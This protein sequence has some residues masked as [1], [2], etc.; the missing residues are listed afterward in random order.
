[1]ENV[2]SDG[3][4]DVKPRKV[5]PEWTRDGLC[6]DLRAS[7][8]EASWILTEWAQNLDE[9]TQVARRRH[10][11][12]VKVA[13]I[14]S[15]SAAPREVAGECARSQ[16]LF[17]VVANK[18]CK[19]RMNAVDITTSRGHKDSLFP[20]CTK[21]LKNIFFFFFNPF[22]C[23]LG[24]RTLCSTSREYTCVSPF[25]SCPFFF[26]CPFNYNL[27][28]ARWQQLRVASSV[29]IAEAP[30]CAIACRSGRVCFVGLAGCCSVSALLRVLCCSAPRSAPSCCS[31]IPS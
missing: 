28:A 3:L 22:L 21:G 5:V 18:T 31:V 24:Y 2:R 27:P 20:C 15:R 30:L 8:E 29:G 4:V 11:V 17:R 14:V 7:L 9:V 25:A 16:N 10:V 12:G 1:M 6:T 19:D 13:H 23:A 26:L